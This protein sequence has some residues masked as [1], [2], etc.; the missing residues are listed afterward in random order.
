MNCP[1]CGTSNLDTA[2]ICANCGRPLASAPAHSYTPPP[3]SHSYAPPA[4]QRIPNYLIPS[5]LVTFCCCQPLGI[6]A[7]IFAA[8]V[9]SK[10]ARGDTAGALNASKN[11]KLFC[12]IA[13]GLTV[14]GWIIA[15]MSGGMTYLE[16]VREAMENR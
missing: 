4:G 14:L 7:I 6:V 2:S 5:I 9:N 10:I 11:A 16:G 15:W 3:G 8:M 12:W 1:N 13:L